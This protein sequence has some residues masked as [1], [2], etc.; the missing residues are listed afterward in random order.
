MQIEIGKKYVNKTWKYLLPCLKQYGPVF[1]TKVSSLYKLAAGINDGLLV[2]PSLKDEKLIYLLIDRRYNYKIS[3]NIMTWLRYQPHVINDYVYDNVE[4]GRKHMF[5]IK[6][7]YLYHE[8]YDKFIEGKYS[9]MYT[10]E[11]VISLY[12]S[13]TEKHDENTINAINVLKKT[14]T[15]ETKFKNKIHASFNIPY[16]DIEIMPEAELDFPLQKHK[17]IFNYEFIKE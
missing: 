3:N 14:V 8:A 15:A 5:V 13:A 10:R 4:G 6:I 12:E 9:E 11:Q 7:P 16:E 17:E 2:N 1:S